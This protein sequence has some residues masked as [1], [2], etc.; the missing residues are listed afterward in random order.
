MG[1][2][3]QPRLALGTKGQPPHFSA[4][5]GLTFT[6]FTTLVMIGFGP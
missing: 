4:V 6:M 1:M 5:F 3:W 2:A